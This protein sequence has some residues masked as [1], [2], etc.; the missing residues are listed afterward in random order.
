MDRRPASRR[1]RRAFLRF[2]QVGDLG[3]YPFHGV[4]LPLLQDAIVYA[5]VGAPRHWHEDADDAIA[6]QNAFC[7]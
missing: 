2:Q 5:A 6:A 4:G 3:E 7:L 1:T